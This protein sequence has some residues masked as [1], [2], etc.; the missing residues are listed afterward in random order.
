MHGVH[1][2]YQGLTVTIRCSALQAQDARIHVQAQFS[3][4][5]NPQ[6]QIV[7]DA[8]MAALCFRESSSQRLSRNNILTFKLEQKKLI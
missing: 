7:S 3:P 5:D 8:G 2:C 1:T 6:H 4:S